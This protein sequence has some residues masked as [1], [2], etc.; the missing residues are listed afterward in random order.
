MRENCNVDVVRLRRDL[1]NVLHKFCVCFGAF[2]VVAVGKVMKDNPH[3]IMV[4]GGAVTW[5][6][7]TL[8]GYYFCQTLFMMNTLRRCQVHIL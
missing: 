5:M 1:H 7:G 2:L 4:R 6:K 3:S 8:G